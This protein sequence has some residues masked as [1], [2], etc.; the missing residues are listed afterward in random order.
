MDAIG[1]IYVIDNEH[2]ANLDMTS[3][4]SAR[5]INNYKL[6][7]NSLMRAVDNV[8]PLLILSCNARDVPVDTIGQNRQQRIGRHMTDKSLSCAQIIELLELHKLKR[9]WLIVDCHV[10]QHQMK[11]IVM[12]FEWILNE[13]EHDCL[14]IKEN[15]RL[16][17]SS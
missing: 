6:E 4:E 7:L 1:Y 11:D 14:H 8:Y 12:G 17:D 15:D 13:I 9:E 3:E 5:V 16:V 2:L 10:L